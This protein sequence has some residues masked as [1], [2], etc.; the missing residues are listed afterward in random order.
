[1]SD[2]RKGRYE[3]IR[4]AFEA[5][6]AVPR[7][8]RD[9]VLRAALADEGELREARAMLRAH[10]EAEGS[11][12]APTVSM[13][14]RGRDDE[15]APG[16][17]ET[18]GPY[19]V[20]RRLGGGGFGEVFLCVKRDGVIRLPVAVKLIR[21]GMD[22]P[23][24][25]GNFKREQQLHG[26]LNHPNIAR[27]LDA[28]EHEGRP[29]LVMEYV[30]G[31]HLDVYCNAKQ[32][33]VQERLELFRTVCRAVHSAHTNL[34]VH[35]DLKPSNIMVDKDGNPRLVDFG[36]AKI[37]NPALGDGLFTGGAQR[38]MTPQYASPEQVSGQTEGT[39]SD[40][41]SLGIV[42][43]ELL[44][45]R[46]PYVLRSAA[47]AEMRR[48]VC[49][50]DPPIPSSVVATEPPAAT[51]DTAVADD[52]AS[53]TQSTAELLATHRDT[54]PGALRRTLQ[55]DIDC[56]VMHAIKKIDR[57]RYASAAEFASDIDNYFDGR[58]LVARRDAWWYVAEKFARR[59]RVATASG[60]VV[61]ATLVLCSVVLFSLLRRAEAAESLAR[62]EQTRTLDVLDHFGAALVDV[63]RDRDGTLGDA[64]LRG[65]AER[66]F[67]S[68]DAL[69]AGD[70]VLLSRA[71]RALESLGQTLGVSEFGGS[72]RQDDADRAFTRAIELR[73]KVAAANPGSV[74][75]AAELATSLR[76]SAA[77]LGRDK[78][79]S[80]RARR[81]A[82][83]TEA[84]GIAERAAA[85]DGES[86][87]VRRSLAAVL[88]AEAQADPKP[89]ADAL[90]ARLLDLREGMVAAAPADA[91]L[92]SE[93]A[94]ALF[95]EG[96]RLD[97]REGAEALERGV[98]AY[99]RSL[100]LRAEVARAMPDQWEPLVR[101]VR[102]HTKL[103]MLFGPDRLDDAGKMKRHFEQARE[104]A[105]QVATRF[106]AARLPPNVRAT[107]V[108][109]Q[110]NSFY[111]VAADPER[112]TR[113][114]EL[115]G[116]VL[117]DNENSRTVVVDL[118]MGLNQ[119]ADSTVDAVE[120]WRRAAAVVALFDLAGGVDAWGGNDA[121]MAGA[122]AR[123]RAT[124]AEVAA[125]V[126]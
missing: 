118:V 78:E 105:D 106:A 11:G 59:H 126:P 16:G 61:A 1:M 5:A 22:S 122:L 14:R 62:T 72:L 35:R 17:P 92:R 18:I 75:A 65:T 101:Q 60:A 28:G 30:D 45:G 71:A 85:A 121:A 6:I 96:D 73:R 41:Y 93:L 100:S 15:V 39:A 123:A 52:T 46:R 50:T 36:I 70:V 43:Y 57:R 47:E 64:T 109:A 110:T 27:L 120:R 32:L 111:Y 23:S 51:R 94:N 91:S 115:A 66:L 42:L 38:L 12:L 53:G 80:S 58:P 3:R 98:A 95:L 40:I 24:I 112:I 86:P 48:V 114:M 90:V 74:V 29:Y 56:M 104:I 81:R 7:N 76:L 97:D 19:E 83:L 99:E 84:R 25:V 2:E 117:V 44:T 8:E 67:A 20:I 89:E 33:S 103:G 9:A 69:P 49:E 124:M 68:V 10:E 63:R 77:N 107:L 102:A 82:M 4:A 119:L 88:F 108:K 125:L 87:E 113:A 79:E 21:K 13:P 26:S 31:Q 37:L 116:G 55:G 34:I 54:K